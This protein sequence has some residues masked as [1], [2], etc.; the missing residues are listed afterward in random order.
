M[1]SFRGGHSSEHRDSEGVAVGHHLV[2]L[3]SEEGNETGV[4]T[5]RPTMSGARYN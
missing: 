4:G 3:D 5:Y 1:R 2:V